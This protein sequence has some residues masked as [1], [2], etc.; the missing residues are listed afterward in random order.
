M[1]NQIR[2]MIK[3]EEEEEYQRYKRKK[4]LKQYYKQIN[5]KK[6]Y[7]MYCKEIKEI[8]C[9]WLYISSLLRKIDNCLLTQTPNATTGTTTPE[10]AKELLFQV[11]KKGGQ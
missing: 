7:N 5:N 4:K 6:M 3:Q 10:E 8:T 11:S 9:K 1:N 2:E